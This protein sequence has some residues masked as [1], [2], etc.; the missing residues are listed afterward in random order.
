MPIGDRSLLRESIARRSLDPVSPSA[1]ASAS[2]SAP[3]QFPLP[4]DHDCEVIRSDAIYEIRN[5]LSFCG[6][7]DRGSGR[8]SIPSDITAIYCRDFPPDGS[9]REI[10]FDGNSRCRRIHGFQSFTSLLRIEIPSS[11]EIISA[12]AFQGCWQLMEGFF[13]ANSSLRKI[14][15]FQGCESLSRIVIPASV[16]LISDSAFLS[17]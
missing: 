3:L 1:S 16:E 17:A 10:V 12:D 6:G 2:A 4:D 5:I 8:L 14:D 9:V 7:T 13:A 11:V 15:G